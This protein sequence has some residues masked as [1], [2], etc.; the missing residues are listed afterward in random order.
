[1]LDVLTMYATTHN[2]ADKGHIHSN[3]KSEVNFYVTACA[4]YEPV[5]G[6]PNTSDSHGDGCFD[7][8]AAEFVPE[9]AIAATS[10]PQVHAFDQ[11][12]VSTLA[13]EQGSI[14]TSTVLSSS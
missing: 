3:G 11:P 13:E 5:S 1:M 2:V 6:Q 8:H 12:W 4:L 10:S 14:S 7:A 9:H